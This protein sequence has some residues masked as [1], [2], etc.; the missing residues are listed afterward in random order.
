MGT[1]QGCKGGDTRWRFKIRS[2]LFAGRRLGAGCMAKRNQRRPMITNHAQMK[3]N[4]SGVEGIGAQSC[5]G[6]CVPLIMP[7]DR[8]PCAPSAMLTYRLHLGAACCAPEFYTI[9]HAA[10]YKQ[11][12]CLLH[13]PHG[14]HAS[15][16]GA[17]APARLRAARAGL[18]RRP[19]PAG[20]ATHAQPG[21][22]KL[23][24]TQR[25]RG[26][27]ARNRHSDQSPAARAPPP[28]ARRRQRSTQK[29]RQ[30]DAPALRNL[31]G[32]CGEARQLVPGKSGSR[33]AQTVAALDQGCTSGA[34]HSPH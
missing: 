15:A 20:G 17:S 5:A 23:P 24:A 9:L 1:R 13:A 30:Q 33:G 2:G 19:T 31:G 25:Q 21:N 10:G 8:R 14:R 18:L 32:A 7:S 6:T 29:P 27:G 11:P 16:H 34:H 12:R 3:R 4:P 26:R 28:S 22:R